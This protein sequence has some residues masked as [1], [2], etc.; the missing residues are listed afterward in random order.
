MITLA[1]VIDDL[2]F[3]KDIVMLGY[4]AERLIMKTIWFPFSKEGVKNIY[5]K[6]PMEDLRI[7]IEKTFASDDTRDKIAPNSCNG[8]FA[9]CLSDLG[10]MTE[11]MDEIL[12]SWGDKDSEE[13]L[14]QILKKVR[15]AVGFYIIQDCKIN[16]IALNE[17][18]LTE[19]HDYLDIYINYKENNNV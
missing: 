4:E 17:D 3:D 11:K 14:Q 18:D 13:K 2:H 19:L 16:E 10:I 15:H 7:H 12:M 9:D 5:F 6:I 8:A 1:S